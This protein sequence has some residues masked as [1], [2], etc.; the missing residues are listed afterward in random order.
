MKFFPIAA[1]ATILVVTASATVP[2]EKRASCKTDDGMLVMMMF[3]APYHVINHCFLKTVLVYIAVTSVPIAVSS[4]QMTP[5][6]VSLQRLPRP[7]LSRPQLPVQES[8]R[9]PLNARP[10]MT[11]QVS[12]GYVLKGSTLT[13][14][15]TLNISFIHR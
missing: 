2:M 11:A 14:S 15:Y 8:P 12:N 5:F 10:M 6:A 13:V 7:L 4:T 9:A 3:I 1:L